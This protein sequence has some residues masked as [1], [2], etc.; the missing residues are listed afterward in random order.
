M[1][2][3]YLF[4]ALQI[5]C[6]YHAYKNNKEGYWYAIIFFIPLIGCVIYLF[7]NVFNQKNTQVIGNEINTVINPSKRITDLIN[8]INFSDTFANRIAL[9]D[10]YFE[11]KEYQNALEN[12]KITLDGAHK[13][14]IYVQEQLVITHFH[15]ENYEKVISLTKSLKETSNISGTKIQFYLGLSYKA[16][17]K[18]NNAEKNLRALDLRYS[19]YQER[20]ILAQFLIEREKKEE[21]QELIEELLTEFNHMG[22]PNKRINRV[23]FV[24]IKKLKES[25]HK[26]T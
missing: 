11:R 15:L 20:L 18:L 3:Y 22:K 16:L 19:N 5:F 25:L 2:Y 4:I 26:N 9:A 17:G 12:Y 14:D 13:N 10:A 6:F 8:Q 23:T 1:R 7:L 24:E 21:A